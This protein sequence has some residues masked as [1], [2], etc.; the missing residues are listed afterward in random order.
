MDAVQRQARRVGPSLSWISL[1]RKSSKKDVENVTF[2]AL[3]G[4]QGPTPSFENICYGKF[5]NNQRT[6]E[7]KNKRI[8][9]SKN[10]SLNSHISSIVRAFDQIPR[11]RAWP[12]IRIIPCQITKVFRTWPKNIFFLEIPQIY[13]FLRYLNL[14]FQH[15]LCFKGTFFFR[16]G[17]FHISFKLKYS[18]LSYSLMLHK[19]I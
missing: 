7:S 12:S 17:H 10:Q 14:F 9:W 8:K 13:T 1:L 19:N 4:V 6:K 15:F 16:F 18:K 11:L 5:L 2:S 3:G